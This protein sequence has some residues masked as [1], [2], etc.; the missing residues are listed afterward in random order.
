MVHEKNNKSEFIEI[1]NCTMKD[2][3]KRMKRQTTD[4]KKIFVK[5]I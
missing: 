2:I 5:H 3:S 1:K 4:L